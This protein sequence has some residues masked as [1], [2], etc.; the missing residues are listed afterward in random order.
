MGGAATMR[1]PL[2]NNRRNWLSRPR[3]ANLFRKEFADH[4]PEEK[5]PGFE[6]AF[7]I[8]QTGALQDK[9]L[10]GEQLRR[11]PHGKL[12]F[13]SDASETI[14]LENPMRNFS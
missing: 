2:P 6:N 5:P 7:K 11:M 3:A 14:A 12:R 10:V 4:A 8:V 13:G 1:E 9:S